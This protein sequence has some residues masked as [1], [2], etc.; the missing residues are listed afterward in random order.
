MEPTRRAPGL[1][2]I[3]L[4]AVAVLAALVLLA[5]G[6]LVVLLPPARLRAVVQE[7]ASR[8]LTRE[9]RFDG[10][11]VGL[12]PPVRVS[13]SGPALAEPGGFD[14]GTAFQAGAIAIDIDPFAL[15]SRRVVVRRIVLDRPALHLVMHADGTT[16]LDGLV[17][18]QPASSSSSG[19]AMDLSVRAFEVRDGRVLVDDVRA[20]RRTAF[21]LETRTS[22]SVEGGRRVATSGT[23]T[24]GG[25]ATGPLSAAKVEELGQSLAKV[26]WTLVH[27]GK[28][29]GAARRLALGR[30]A[31]TFERTALTLSGIVDDPGPRARV[32]LRARGAGV[33]IAGLLRVLSA[34]DAAALHGISGGGRLDF[35]LRILGALG[36]AA[37]PRV[38]G[39]LSLADGAFRYTGA[40]ASV[41]GLAF[42]ARFAPDSLLIPDARASVAGQP[43]RAALGVTRFADPMV[44]FRLQ[45][46]VDLA[47]VAPLAAPRAVT[48]GGQARVDVRGR[49]RA[50]DP[51][52]MALE[53]AATLRGVRVAGPAL[54]APVE[55]V[56][57]EIVF[58]PQAAE[59]RKLSAKAGKSSFTLDAK[60]TRPLALM[61]PA[62]K[63]APAGVDFTLDSPYL[64]LAE[65]LPPTPGPALLPNA[66][67]GGRV[68]IG[69]LRNQRLDVGDVRARVV[70]TPTSLTVP[71]FSL[72]GYD[73]RV[74]GS[75][76][77]DLRDPASPGFDVK[78][79]VDSVSADALLSAWTPAKGLLRG[80]MSTDLALAGDGTRPEQL[81]RSLTA[82]GL[83]SLLNGQIGPGPVLEAVAAATGVPGLKEARFKDLK[84]PFQVERG[85]VT[86]REVDLRT[87]A[88]D[89]KVS[90]AIGFDGALDYA[91]SITV[92]PDQV[93]RLGARA[94]LAAGALSDAQGRMLIDLRVGGTAAS[95]KVSLDTGAM[96]A[97]LAGRASDALAQQ[98]ARLET[99]LREAARRRLSAAPG[100]S[101][102]KVLAGPTPSVDSLKSIGRDLLRG[103]FAKPRPKPVTVDSAAVR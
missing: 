42:A 24:L 23:T 40:P 99:D 53:G 64:D 63:V 56:N 86:T 33:D 19:P 4:L 41:S 1:S 7:Q 101:S 91:M 8:L 68:R 55:Q 65:L 82:V 89:W 103:F 46:D 12:L 81:R 87:S 71:E 95:P 52:T 80:V 26:R 79:A 69:R 28:F 58:S 98:K 76:A 37:P 78:A 29:D 14:H 18:A 45:G 34:A 75:A 96:K 44:T 21:T 61:A 70:M 54:P 85:R 74:H 50:R 60:V 100:D 36:A 73:G 31:L 38:T 72:R 11:S 20:G 6:A 16:N 27:E 32:D 93:E 88:G 25:L 62:G 97:R 43:V 94:A 67:G 57:G 84:L 39:T 17:K 83:A 49:G 35:D 13:V 90:G 5:W 66:A 22:L 9:V 77:F 3:A 2:R 59:V 102:G 15:L 51:G 10:V 30:L 92:P 48:L 47:A